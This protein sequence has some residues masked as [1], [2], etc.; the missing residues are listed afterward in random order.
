[1]GCLKAIL[2]ENFC[3]SSTGHIVLIQLNATFRAILEVSHEFTNVL[4]WSDELDKFSERSEVLEP[5]LTEL[6]PPELPEDELSDFFSFCFLA[7]SCL[8]KG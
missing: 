4:S 3:P 8:K 2:A 6:D 7:D 1:M 5:E